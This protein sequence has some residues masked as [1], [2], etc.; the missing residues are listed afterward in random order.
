MKKILIPIIVLIVLAGVIFFTLNKKE[1]NDAGNGTIAGTLTYRDRMALPDDS[2]VT[3]TLEDISLAD[4]PAVKI[5]EITFTTEGY[6][7]PLNFTLNYD[8]A[9]IDPKHT[10]SVS[11]KVYSNNELIRNTTDNYSVITNGAKTENLE[12]I[13]NLV[14][15][16]EDNT[17]A[18]TSTS[19][20]DINKKVSANVEIIGKTFNLISVNGKTIPNP[21]GTYKV[22]FE[23]DRI[24][25]KFCN[26]VGGEY[27]L[28]DNILSSPNM[29][30]TEMYC[31]SPDG[32]MDAENIFGK[33][34]FDGAKI[35][36]SGK[37]LTIERDGNQMVFEAK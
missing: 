26:G 17:N 25:A 15:P 30:S 34:V 29:V 22:T 14:N 24:S 12:L 13:L 33:L 16:E 1:N 4:A 8:T 18:T 11:A 21:N 9:K 10:Y 6:Q 5:A 19:S 3:V 20:D 35:S 2:V 37:T 7:V 27:T 36:L 23:A 32:L 31:T 28:R